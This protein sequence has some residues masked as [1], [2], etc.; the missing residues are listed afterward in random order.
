MMGP[1]TERGTWGVPATGLPGDSSRKSCLE[2][3]WEGRS[4]LLFLISF[5]HWSKGLYLLYPSDLLCTDSATSGKSLLP[6]SSFFSSTWGL[7]SYLANIFICFLHPLPP[8]LPALGHFLQHTQPESELPSV[9]ASAPDKQRL[10]LEGSRA[11]AM[12]ALFWVFML[13]N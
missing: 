12:A 1:P 3:L 5:C 4:W 13:H 6:S 2:C 10:A 9:L 11:V 7:N 8:V